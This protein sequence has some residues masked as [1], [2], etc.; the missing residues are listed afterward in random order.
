MNN[1]LKIFLSSPSNLNTE[2]SI[3]KDIVNKI[4]S[5]FAD[6]FGIFIIVKDSD[7]VTPAY[8]RPQSIINPHVDDCDLFLGILWK[9]WGQ[10]TGE[11]DSGFFEE[12]NRA[13]KRR[14][15]TGKPEIWLYFKKIS[16][17]LL[18]DQ[19]PQLKKVL[20]FKDKIMEEKKVYYG[21]FSDE[22]DW[23]DKIYT[24]LLKYIIKYSSKEEIREIEP[25]STIKKIEKKEY[26]PV[27]S[28]AYPETLVDLFKKVQI[29]MNEQKGVDSL[30][31]LDV[32]R[33]YLLSFTWFSKVHYS[34]IL[35]IHEISLIYFYK[36]KI[37]LSPDE[38]ILIIRSLIG[39]E[40]DLRPGWFWF[41]SIG[42]RK[43]KKFII[44]RALNDNNPDVR[45]GAF[46]I[47]VDLKFDIS[48]KIIEEGLNDKNDE[49]RIQVVKLI[50][51]FKID[52]SI[53][54]LKPI[55][56]AENKSLK[57]AAIN[58]FTYLSFSKNPKGTILWILN[59]EVSVPNFILDYQYSKDI[60]IS[61]NKLIG[62][63]KTKE[64]SIRVLTAK[65]LR[66]KKIID[67]DIC[68][69]LINDVDNQVK[70]EGF[71]GLLD[72]GEEV[73]INLVR[74]S[75][76]GYLA[77]PKKLIYEIIKKKSYEEILKM[78]DWFNAN[79][80]IAYK[81]LAVEHYKD[82][83]NIL[84]KD[85]KSD[86]ETI[87]LKSI[88]NFTTKYRITN[89]G[90]VDALL[91]NENI[92]KFIKSEFISSALEGL[93]Q[94]GNK[95]DVKYA[96]K[97][98]GKTNYNTADRVAIEMIAKYGNTADCK[99]LLNYAFNS[100]SEYKILPIKTV[101]SLRK[102]L[103]NII[104]SML[105]SN[106]K[107]LLKIALL[108][109]DSL[110]SQ[111]NTKVAKEFLKNDDEAVRLI[112][113]KFL[114]LKYNKD[115]LIDILNDY[116]KNDSYYYNVVTWLDRLIYAPEYFEPIFLNKIK[117]IENSVSKD[118]RFRDYL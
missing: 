87:K 102:N 83:E 5:N 18:T 16:K 28:L 45:K 44:S 80:H 49:V 6:E 12:F 70:K 57:E 99:M 10:P 43:L 96:R 88:K 9:R 25:V 48:L 26:E 90:E 63:L 2:K 27:K 53:K 55:L 105:K 30:E 114:F 78:I 68:K 71:L 67:K 94:H 65:L 1:K 21:E 14:E 29:S 117:E 77:D 85:I 3:T 8:G 34:E 86:F 107:D 73:D 35:G 60:K 72:L 118:Y 109:L 40:S 115:E 59:N 62:A 11:F 82:F 106:D 31:Y 66:I 22:D 81:V 104:S 23:R 98:L 92:N 75:I 19:G 110:K 69:N 111:N 47:L 20:S 39:D 91:K 51:A 95:N 116:I 74:E 54:L 79:A 64:S 101:L 61:K 46:S 52:R 7:N 97:Y 32:V 50:K 42:K 112:S 17:D 113:I 100:K 4:S 24:F 15:S 36:E 108:N 84:R 103:S 38:I 93:L 37:E 33:L 13:I 76:K 56:E 41:K 89:E 58:A